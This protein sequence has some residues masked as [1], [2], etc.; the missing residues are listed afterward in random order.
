[1]ISHQH[2]FHSYIIYYFGRPVLSP[3][4]QT[5]VI[6]Q[7]LWHRVKETFTLPVLR[8]AI[9]CQK[10]MEHWQILERN[11]EQYEITT[12]NSDA[13]KGRYAM[14]KSQCYKIDYPSHNWMWEKAAICQGHLVWY[15]VSSCKLL[16]TLHLGLSLCFQFPHSWPHHKHLSVCQTSLGRFF[17]F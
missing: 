9:S 1:M 15:K 7:Q 12:T 17:S 11:S 8:Y 10:I 13:Y 3:N 2:Y 6:V 5:E 14:I 16:V 4:L